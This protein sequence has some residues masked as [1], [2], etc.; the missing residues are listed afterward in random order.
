MMKTL[1]VTLSLAASL[2]VGVGATA[3][4]ANAHE[5]WVACNTEYRAC[6]RGGANMSLGNGAGNASNWAGCNQALAA[7]YKNMN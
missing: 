5:G 2:M 7:C 1:L 3:A 4:L 6:I